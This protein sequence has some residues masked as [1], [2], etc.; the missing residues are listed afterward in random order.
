MKEGGETCIKTRLISI[1]S[2]HIKVVVVDVIIV[3]VVVVQ[4]E[5]RSKTILGTKNT[6]QKKFKF[7]FFFD[8][9]NFW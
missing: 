6:S 1:V 8:R 2:K 7:K 9:I 4:K 5:F 3:V